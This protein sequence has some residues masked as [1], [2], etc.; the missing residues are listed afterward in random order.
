MRAVVVLV[1]TLVVLA[2]CGADD[3][4]GTAP[5]PATAAA[6][7]ATAATDP[8]GA[9]EADD[10][11]GRACPYVSAEALGEALVSTAEP[12]S[13]SE[14]SC[15]FWTGD[16][17][18]IQ[19][20]RVAVDGDPAVA[21]D[22]ARSHCVTDTV[23]DVVAGEGAFACI[24]IGANGTVV[25]DGSLISLGATGSSDDIAVRDAFVALLPQVTPS[26]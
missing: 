21:L 15:A 19:V 17:V 13:G 4:G 20:T 24:A 7:E 5:A 12:I 23:V 22:Q 9:D 16:D 25:A 26:P 1:A 10:A 6:D 18:R 2:G 8:P 14:A 11:A 3:D